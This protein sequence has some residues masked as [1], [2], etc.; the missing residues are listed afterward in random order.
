VAAPI[1]PDGSVG[2]VY[3]PMQRIFAMAIKRIIISSLYLLA[4]VGFLACGLAVAQAQQFSA[5]LVATDVD[6]IATASAGKLRVFDDKVRIETPDYADGFFLIEGANRAA[7]FV[8]PAQRIFMEARQ[9]SRFTQ[10][11]VGVDPTDPC[12]QWQIMAQV[13]GAVEAGDPWR[14]E[15]LSEEVI[16]GRPVAAYQATLPSGKHFVGWIDPDLKFPLQIRMED[17]AI[18]AARNIQEG[19]QP[20]RLFEIPA[21]FHKFDAQALIERI[22]QSDVWVEPL[23]R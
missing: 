18:I 8:R 6:G 20:K 7:H 16:D 17:G 5:D 13:A 11:F 15:H 23:P 22:K 19:P 21:G 4:V 12:R 2:A 10:M 9:S 3:G 1:G 14:C